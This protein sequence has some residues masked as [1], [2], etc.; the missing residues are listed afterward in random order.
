VAG[1]FGSGMTGAAYYSNHNAMD[2]GLRWSA[3][4]Y[5]SYFASAMM[6][7]FRPDLTLLAERL[8]HRKK[9]D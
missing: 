6:H 7:E 2:M 3:I 8:L 5:G 4:T 9:A 1:A